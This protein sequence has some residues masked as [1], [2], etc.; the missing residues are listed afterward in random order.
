VKLFIGAT[1]RTRANACLACG[2]LLDAATPVT[3]GPETPKQNGA[4]TACI[5]CGHVMVFGRKGRLR[6]PTASEQKEIDQIPEMQAVLSAI[7]QRRRMQ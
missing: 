3:P 7:A 5:H 1:Q 2:A 6:N 4:A